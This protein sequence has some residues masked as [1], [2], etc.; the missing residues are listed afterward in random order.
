MFDSS[1]VQRVLELA[2]RYA[3]IAVQVDRLN[4]LNKP[5]GK[6]VGDR[7]STFSLLMTQLEIL[8]SIVMVREL[9][10]IDELNIAMLCDTK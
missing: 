7:I 8:D 3:D 5:C 10:T 4:R 6:L 9:R 1:R 2:K